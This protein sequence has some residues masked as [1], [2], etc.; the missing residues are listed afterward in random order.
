MTSVAEVDS[1]IGFEDA[2]F[3]DRPAY[4]ARRDLQASETTALDQRANVLCL[5]RDKPPLACRT[6]HR[7]PSGLDRPASAGLKYSGEG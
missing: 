4:R 6:L 5:D 7:A 1:T 2:E 3:I